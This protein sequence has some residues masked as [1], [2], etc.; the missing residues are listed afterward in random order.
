MKSRDFSLEVQINPDTARKVELPE[1]ELTELTKALTL[2]DMPP[3]LQVSL[4]FAQD[5]ANPVVCKWDLAPHDTSCSFFTRPEAEEYGEHLVLPGKHHKGE[6]GPQT[7]GYNVNVLGR[8]DEGKLSYS[9]DG[10][11]RN[12]DWFA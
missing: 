11:A 12:K 2:A 4:W 7:F 9:Q 8:N 6:G 3:K 5:K 10:G 1:A